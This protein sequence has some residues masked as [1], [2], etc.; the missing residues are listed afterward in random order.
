MISIAADANDYLD[1]CRKLDD[2]QIRRSQPRGKGT[3]TSGVGDIKTFA[4]RW[5][6]GGEAYEAQSVV[7][8]ATPAEL[9]RWDGVD[10]VWWTV[11]RLGRLGLL[12]HLH[13]VG[14]WG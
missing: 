5:G 9:Y 14:D 7:L 12:E 2:P 6:R 1:G 8:Q 3:P 13:L 11:R 10:P 4:P